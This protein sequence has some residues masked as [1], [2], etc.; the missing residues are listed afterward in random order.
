[1]DNFYFEN[2]KGNSNKF[3][4]VE[5][6]SKDNVLFF[7]TRRWGQIGKEGTTLKETCHSFT[8]AE[9]RRQKLIKEKLAKGYEAVL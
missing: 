4:A 3:W 6:E 8:N 5:I 9:I 1:M 7:L 2:T